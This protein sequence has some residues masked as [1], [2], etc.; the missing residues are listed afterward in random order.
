MCGLPTSMPRPGRGTP[1][2][3]ARTSDVVG[4]DAPAAR[5]RPRTRGRCGSRDFT[6]ARVPISTGASARAIGEPGL[7]E[8]ARE[9]ADAVAAHLGL[10][11]VGV[12][13]VH[14]PLGTGG[15]SAIAAPS[16]MALERTTRRMPS[17]PMPKR[18]S[19]S[20]ATWSSVRSSAPSGSAISD[21]VVAGAVTFGEVRRSAASSQLRRA[22]PG[23][24]GA[25]QTAMTDS[26]RRRVNA[27]IVVTRPVSAGVRHPPRMCPCHIGYLEPGH[28]PARVPAG[29]RLGLGD[30]LRLS[31]RAVE[32][33]ERLRVADRAARGHA[34]LEPPGAE[35][36]D[37]VEEPVRPHA[38]ARARR[39]AATSSSR[40]LRAGR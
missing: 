40:G 15:S 37:L 34:A 12:A 16:S 39:V 13:V 5:G 23:Q 26:V 25:R 38:L 7:G 1:R 4:L 36:L 28:L 33:G 2:P 31:R 3:R 20:T 22:R 10:R 29:E 24:A 17:A 6:P 32:L 14:E 11:A 30:R 18:R 21:E 19:H 35:L 8:V 27:P 9:D